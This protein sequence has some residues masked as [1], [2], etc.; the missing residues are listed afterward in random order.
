MRTGFNSACYG[1]K[2]RGGLGFRRAIAAA[3]AEAGFRSTFAET[4]PVLVRAGVATEDEL[5]GLLREMQETAEDLRVLIAQAC[6]P[7][8][9]P[10]K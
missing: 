9:V 8:V 7:G 10:L 2:T 4:V 5:K 6:L 3:A 1:E